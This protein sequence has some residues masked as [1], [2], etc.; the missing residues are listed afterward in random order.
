MKTLFW[1]T[2]LV[3]LAVGLI[4]RTAPKP[5]MPTVKAGPGFTLRVV[6]AGVP[7]KDEA[8]DLARKIIFKYADREPV[9]VI[10]QDGRLLL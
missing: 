2:A 5:K 6:F 3:L 10:H 8:S 1:A 4:D 7:S 9:A